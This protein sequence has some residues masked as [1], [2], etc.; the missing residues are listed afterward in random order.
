MP[1]VVADANVLVS[2]ALARSPQAP[3]VLTLDAALDGRVEL[4]TSPALLR[5]VTKVL[6]RPRLR[7][8]VSA[9]EAVRFVADLAAQTVLLVDPP[10]PHRA[11]CRDPATTI[12]SHSLRPVEPRR[13]SAGTSTC[14]PLIPLSSASR[15]SR[16]GSSPIGWGSLEQASQATIARA[17][18][19]SGQP[20]RSFYRRGRVVD[21]IRAFAMAYAGFRRTQGLA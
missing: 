9:D 16:R 1:R 13:S 20:G 19:R 18:L 14:L 21:I 5:E 3:S 17:M 10:G 15:S 6:A 11:V 4:V 7:K 12:S 8:Y 2:A